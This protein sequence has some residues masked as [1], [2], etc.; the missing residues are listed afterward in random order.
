MQPAALAPRAGAASKPPL[1]LRAPLLVVPAAG[2][3]EG[4][5]SVAHPPVGVTFFHMPA[6]V[7]T[8]KHW[9][10]PGSPPAAPGA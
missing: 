5:V 1:L 10:Y 6:R 8:F 2:T 4:R 7:S 3:R 9:E